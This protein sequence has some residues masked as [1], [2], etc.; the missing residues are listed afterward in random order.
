M[1]KGKIKEYKVKVGI[2][3][4]PIDDINDVFEIKLPISDDEVE[5]I[6]K[7]DL[8][9][10]W[11]RN[12][13]YSWQYIECFAPEAYK[14]GIGLAEAYC[15]PKWG[16]KMKVENGA[17]YE[18]FLPDKIND[19]IINDPRWIN[20]NNIRAKQR[21]ASELQFHE[22]HRI[23][24]QNNDNGRFK[25]KLIGDPLWNNSIFAGSWSESLH[26]YAGEYGFHTIIL[27]G[28]EFSYQRIYRREFVEFRIDL[29]PPIDDYLEGFF[30]Q[31]NGIYKMADFD[32][33]PNYSPPAMIAKSKGDLCDIEFYM[34]FLE[35]IVSQQVGM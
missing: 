3:Y 33:K 7:G 9:L 28:V 5:A 27:N 13:A 19:K 4:P 25:N 12:P 15:V 21:E 6:I 32:M 26:D 17:Y 31:Y 34:C 20:E 8:N 1:S 22:D 29:R 10:Y 24:Y 2:D 18:F 14:K 35:Y 11:E 30:T 16:D 23:F